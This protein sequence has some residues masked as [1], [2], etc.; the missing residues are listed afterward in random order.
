MSVKKIVAWK[1]RGGELHE[2]KL[3]AEQ[4]DYW[5]AL[6]EAFDGEDTFLNKLYANRELVRGYLDATETRWKEVMS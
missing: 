6:M 4:A 5:L 2:S 3:V 1:D